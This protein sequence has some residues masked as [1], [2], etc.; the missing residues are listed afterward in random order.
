MAPRATWKGHLTL[1]ALSCPVALYALVS[2]GERI[3]LHTLDRR[4]GHR[5]RR[6][7]V[8]AETGK[9]VDRDAQVKGYDTGD[10]RHILLEQEEIDAAVP[11]STHRIEI[12]S[13]VAAADFDPVFRDRPYRLAPTDRSGREVFAVVRAAMAAGG[14]VGIGRTVLFRRD[15][16]L[17]LAPCASGFAAAT[18]HFDYEVRAAA[19]ILE[20]V[21][22]RRLDPEMIDLVRHIIGTR[23]GRFDPDAFEDR[24]EAA[25]GELIRAK[26]AGKKL[27]KPRPA[28]GGEVIDL[29]DALRRSAGAKAPAPKARSGARTGTSRR[30][31]AGK[32][33]APARRR[34]AG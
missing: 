4:S 8:D 7:F 6:Q 19:S 9:P 16:A 18:L 15:R 26:Q 12:E 21:P 17:L 27:P 28:A 10:G 11:A 30:A 14:V 23:R 3:R 13:F 20:A 5:V 31:A 29:M 22:D 25:L 24:Y 32:S 34:R 33:A 1:G 2:E